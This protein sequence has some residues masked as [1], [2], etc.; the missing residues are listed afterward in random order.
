MPVGGERSR[1]LAGLPV[2]VD[3]RCEGKDAC[4][5]SA[6]EPGG[7]LGEVVFEPE[8]VFERVDD[9][10]DPL[11]DAADRRL[12]AFRL[13]ASARAQQQRAEVGDGCFEIGAC[14][15]FVGDHELTGGRL[16]LEQ[17]EQGL[18]LGRVGGDELK[19]RTQPSGPHQSTSRIPQKKRE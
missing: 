6:D 2:E 17:F 10:L 16:S 12:L 8:L 15:A 19:S 11:A 3:G 13:V 5:D 4:G 7:G 9:R 1:G 18:A 14:E